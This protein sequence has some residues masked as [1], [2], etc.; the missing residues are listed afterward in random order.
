MQTRHLLWQSRPPTAA[1]LMAAW[2]WTARST[3]RRRSHTAT[4]GA[5]TPPLP[6]PWAPLYSTPADLRCQRASVVILANMPQLSRFSVES[7]D[8]RAVACRESSS[9]AGASPTSRTRAGGRGEHEGCA[10]KA[11]L[12]RQLPPTAV[13]PGPPQTLHA[14][15]ART[16]QQQAEQLHSWRRCLRKRE[17]F[18]VQRRGAQ[19][20][21][22]ACQVAQE[23]ALLALQNIMLCSAFR[24]GAVDH[25]WNHLQH[26]VHLFVCGT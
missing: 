3:H 22:H 18:R 19:H 17:R 7:M 20:A 6:T 9:E 10:R 26:L 1:W 25:L 4:A 16:T 13:N 2:R 8:I 5:D 12:V 23:C 14:R 24:S 21:L 15:D 11:Q